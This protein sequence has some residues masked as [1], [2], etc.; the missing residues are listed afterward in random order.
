MDRDLVRQLGW[1]AGDLDARGYPF[2]PVVRRGA[3][4]LLNGDA[5]D[6]DGGCVGC[7]QPVPDTPRGRPRKWCGERCRRRHRP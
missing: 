2:A 4:A 1:V 7:G 3:R 5:P 6:R